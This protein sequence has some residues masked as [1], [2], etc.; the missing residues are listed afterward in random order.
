MFSS[1]S[2]DLWCWGQPGQPKVCGHVPRME[3]TSEGKCL[4]SL[5][6]TFQETWNSTLVSSPHPDSCHKA[7]VQSQQPRPASLY[8]HLCFDQTDSQG[9]LASPPMCGQYWTKTD[10]RMCLSDLHFSQEG[11]TESSWF[12]LAEARPGS[13]NTP[14]TSSD[15]RPWGAEQGGKHWG[16][17]RVLPVGEHPTVHVSLSTFLNCLISSSMDTW[18]HH[19]C[20]TYQKGKFNMVPWRL[21]QDGIRLTAPLSGS[22]GYW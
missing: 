3:S 18:A 12:S 6:V 22:Q 17:Q 7:P 8:L 13:E 9:V 21:T 1:I 4:I 10:S 2:P 5:Q 11:K 19:R 20:L 16:K 15:F 14:Y